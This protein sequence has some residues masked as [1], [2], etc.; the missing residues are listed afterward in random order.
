MQSHILRYF[1][2]EE[3]ESMAGALAA[4]YSSGRK[5]DKVEVDYTERR[6]LRKTPGGKPGFVIYHTN[7]SLV[8]KPSLEGLTR[9]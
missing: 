7:Y 6:N 1:P 3:L 9:Q 2:K 5:A 8:A 4:W